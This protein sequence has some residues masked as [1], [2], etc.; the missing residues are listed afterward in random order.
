[1]PVQSLWQR[2]FPRSAPFL[3]PTLRRPTLETTAVLLRS[4]PR[5][6]LLER[7]VKAWLTF[8]LAVPTSWE[9][10]SLSH[11]HESTFY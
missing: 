2:P 11:L 1:L 4:S 8:R 10:L 9:T 3:M 5:V 7:R 6:F